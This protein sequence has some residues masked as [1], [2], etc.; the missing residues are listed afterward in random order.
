MKI[1]CFA[2][3]NYKPISELRR[4]TNIEERNSECIIRDF[5]HKTWFCLS[6]SFEDDT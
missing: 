2:K 3:Y 6:I 1:T 5:K 4:Q